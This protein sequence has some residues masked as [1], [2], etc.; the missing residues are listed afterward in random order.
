MTFKT[1]QVLA[2]ASLVVG[3]NAEE[4]ATSKLMVHVSLFVARFG[5]LF[6]EVSL[7]FFGLCRCT[8]FIY[9]NEPRSREKLQVTSCTN[10]SYSK[11]Y[12]TS[13][14]SGLGSKFV[15]FGEIS[16]FLRSRQNQPKVT[17]V[18]T[19]DLL[20]TKLTIHR[21]QQ[22]PHSLYRS[23]GYD[24]KEALF[25]MPPYGG[26]IAQNLYYADDDLCSGNAN[27]TGGYPERDPPGAPWP[28]PFILMVD[29]G[30]CSFTTKVRSSYDFLFFSGRSPSSLP[31]VA[32][33]SRASH[34]FATLSAS[35]PLV[36]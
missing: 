12:L 24:H 6:P 26:S 3:S 34:R 30:T 31:H 17:A 35:V 32:S 28:S 1:A 27:V 2:I 14:E 36:C 29:R 21:L 5:L 25:G 19:C 22:I 33:P 13:Y 20:L 11:H 8:I 18:V 7:D 4:K 23:E 15:F 16:P 10:E 9:K